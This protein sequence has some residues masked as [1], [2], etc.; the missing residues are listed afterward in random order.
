MVTAVEELNEDGVRAI[1]TACG[2]FSGVQDVLAQA[3]KVPVFTSA[4]MLV[5]VVAR[6]IGRNRKVGIVTASKSLLTSEFLESVGVDQSHNIVIAGAE[7][8]TEFF[9]THMGGTRIT[10]DVELLR[11][12][13]VEIVR[14]FHA[15]HPGL[16]AL[17]VECSGFSTF[18]ADFQRVTGLPEFDYITFIELMYRSVVQRSYHGFL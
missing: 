7:T 3:S 6:M 11:T 18:S 8:S 15:E 13:L 10:M 4:L 5:P 17:L 2:F 16:G 9:A 12:E 1:V 14:G